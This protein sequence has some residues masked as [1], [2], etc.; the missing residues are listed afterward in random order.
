MSSSLQS[1]LSDEAKFDKASRTV[2]DSVD[3]DRSGRIDKRELG[4]ALITF[5]KE[6]G[7]SPPS[8]VDIDKSFTQ[9]DLDRSGDIDYNEFKVYMRRLLEKMK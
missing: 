8:Q 4:N 3:S 2:F 1:I 7:I 6:A 9:L 5:S